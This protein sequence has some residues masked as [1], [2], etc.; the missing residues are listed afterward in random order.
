MLFAKLKR[1]LGGY[2]TEKQLNSWLDPLPKTI[3][4][5]K[6]SLHDKQLIVYNHFHEGN[7]CNHYILSGAIRSGK[8][9]I[10]AFLFI[11]FIL[12]NSSPESKNLYI[13]SGYTIGSIRLNLCQILDS[14]GFCDYRLTKKEGDTYLCVGSTN[15]I[16]LAGAHDIRAFQKIRGCTVKGWYAN[17]VTL[18]HPELIKECMRRVSTSPSIKIWDCNPTT[19][20]HFIYQDFIM[21]EDI[22]SGLKHFS[23][24][25]YE[26]QENLPPDYIDL[27]K[28]Y[29]SERE[30]KL[31]LDGEWV[32]EGTNPFDNLKVID[33][34]MGLFLNNKSVK[35]AFLDPATGLAGS[36]SDSALTLMTEIERH[37][38]MVT[39][40]FGFIFQGGYQNQLE[41][42]F[43]LL[44]KF[45]INMFFYENNL[46][47][48]NTIEMS[49]DGYKNTSIHIDSIRNNA[50]KIARIANLIAPIE[51]GYL[52]GCNLGDEE[53]I[54]NVRNAELSENSSVKL[55]AIDALESG[56]RIMRGVI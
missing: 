39:V 2:F 15:D 49:Y 6:K 22:V 37:G 56:Y 5:H 8:T 55:D 11:E 36:G 42:I 53:F 47:G 29:M 51:K 17:E 9:Y 14:I 46:I 28:S 21:K 50:N 3:S 40:F 20:L 43:Q 30:Q 4:Y 48:E 45:Q 33:Y 32:G 54:N 35:L 41:R 23:F 18:Q 12:N 25:I 13:A 34:N 38:A 44:K 1:E 10:S 27:Q 52:I 31:Y 19:P 7:K 24:S 16:L 26:N